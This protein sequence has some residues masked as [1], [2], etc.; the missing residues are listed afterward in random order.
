MPNISNIK[1]I[2]IYIYNINI[3]YIIISADSN[4][5]QGGRPRS[6]GLEGPIK[7]SAGCCFLA[8]W[9][10]TFNFS[11]VQKVTLNRAACGLEGLIKASAGCCFRR[12]VSERDCASWLAATCLRLLGRVCW[13]ET[14]ILLGF[15]RWR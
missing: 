3:K 5:R 15:R 11:R 13:L 14:F 9:L 6:I 1:Y 8:G 2:I 7:Y 12:R 10:E 4:R